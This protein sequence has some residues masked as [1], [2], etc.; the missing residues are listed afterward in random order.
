MWNKVKGTV[1][2]IA[3]IPYIVRALLI[4]WWYRRKKIMIE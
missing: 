2:L 4:M 1:T 3:M